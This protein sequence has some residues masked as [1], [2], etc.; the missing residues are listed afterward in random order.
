MALLPKFHAGPVTLAAVFL[1]TASSGCETQASTAPSPKDE[2]HVEMRNISYHYTD[3]IAV[4]VETLEGT[5]KSTEPGHIPVFDDTKSFDIEVSSA[6]VFVTVDSMAHVLNDYVLAPKDAPIKQISIQT[7]GNSLIVKGKKGAMPFEATATLSVTADGEIVL[8]TEKV[9]VAHL[10]VKGMMEFLGL[11]LAD[12]INTKKIHGI[13][14]DGDNLILNTEKVLP[15]PHFHGKISSVRVQ[16]NDIVETIGN[17]RKSAPLMR[18]NYMAYRGGS[19]GFGKLT[20]AET[21][22]VLIDMDAKDPFDFY[23]QRYKE[24]LT[25]G[26]SKTTSTFGLRVYMPDFNKL[27]GQRRPVA[28]R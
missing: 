28:G 10:P 9:G 25:A 20:M 26:Y 14:A 8:H 16:G 22:L 15:P 11:E 4:H 17:P 21:D 5:L 27:P 3:Q 7:K 13:R 18:G 23:F 12:L 1:L 19:I 24:Q 6:Q 2:I